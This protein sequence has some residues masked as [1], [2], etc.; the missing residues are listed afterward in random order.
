LAYQNDQWEGEFICFIFFAFSGRPSHHAKP[1][2]IAET[3][4]PIFLPNGRF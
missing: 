4:A 3:A 1:A 2:S